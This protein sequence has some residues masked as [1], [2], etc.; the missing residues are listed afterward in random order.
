MPF[1]YFD[2]FDGHEVVRDEEGQ[3]CLSLRSAQEEAEESARELAGMTIA[4][5]AA[6]DAREIRVRDTAGAVV[7][8]MRLKDVLEG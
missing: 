1:F 3:D 4:R 7:F 6:I 5:H 2:V 8:T